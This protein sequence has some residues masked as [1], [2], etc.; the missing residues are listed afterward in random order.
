MRTQQCSQ[1][2]NLSRSIFVFMVPGFRQPLFS[3]TSIQI[4]IVSRCFKGASPGIILRKAV[5]VISPRNGHRYTEKP[6][7]WNKVP[8][9]FLIIFERTKMTCSKTGAVISTLL[10]NLEIGWPVRVSTCV[11]K[12]RSRT[13]GKAAQ[14]SHV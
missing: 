3:C 8:N 7:I 4:S 12:C 13:F 2:R 10:R 11:G 1:N 5:E 9:L 6:S 14:H